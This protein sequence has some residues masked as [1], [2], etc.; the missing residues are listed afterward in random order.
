MRTANVEHYG[1]CSEFVSFDVKLFGD[2]V[3][4]CGGCILGRLNR[5]HVWWEA[6]DVMLR[7]REKKVIGVERQSAGKEI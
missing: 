7:R 4:C 5:G 3:V 6:H 2:C 1:T